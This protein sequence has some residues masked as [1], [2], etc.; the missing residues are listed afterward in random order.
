MDPVFLI[1][2]P[3]PVIADLHVGG[4]RL[5]D[6]AVEGGAGG[7]PL[8]Q[9]LVHPAQLL[10]QDADVVL[11]AGLLLLL[12]VDLSVELVPLGAQLLDTWARERDIRTE[13]PLDRHR[14]LCVDSRSQH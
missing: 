3:L 2:P 14:Y 13:R 1:F 10:R 9:A 6:G 8:G 11:Q 12:L 4:F 5:G 7:Q